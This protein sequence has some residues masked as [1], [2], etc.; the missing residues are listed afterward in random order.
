MD[1]G[2]WAI[3]V[4]TPIQTEIK[5][6]DHSHI[7]TLQPV[8]TLINL[9]PAYSAFTSDIKLP[10]YLKQYSKGF[11]VA[12][13]S[14]NLHISEFTPAKFR[15][16]THIDLSNVTQPEVKNLR[17]LAL[18]LAIPIGQLRVQ[19]ANFRHINSDKSRPWI[20]FVGA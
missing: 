3:L 2:H 7:K 14:A 5:C 6:E 18:A 9:Q 12:L 20:Y 8:I 13:K 16:W 19:I 10:P 11:H 1:Q 15:I 17:K 4:E